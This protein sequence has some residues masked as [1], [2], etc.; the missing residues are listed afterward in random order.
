MSG[1][2]P[3]RPPSGI[4]S[5][6]G[7][8]PGSSLGSSGSAPGSAQG[9]T[10]GSSPGSSAGS[11]P[12]S[13][14]GSVPGSVPGS[15]PG[16]VPGSSLGSSSGSSQSP[17]PS[18]GS[19]PPAA[20][21]V[22]GEA[23]FATAVASVRGA[24]LRPEIALEE[25]PAPQRLAPF[26]LALS[27]DV[28]AGVGLFSAADDAD[29]ASGRLVLLHDPAGHQAWQGVFRLVTYVRA[30]LDLDMAADPLLPS[31]G[32][33]WLHEA[34]A[35]HGAEFTAIGG[36]VTLVR[37]EPFGSMADDPANAEIEIRASWTPLRAAVA[38]HVQ[39]WGDVLAQAAGLPPLPHGV[40]A[41]PVP[42]RP[43]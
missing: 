27:A 34:L 2:H 38:A 11:S 13:S 12:G 25:T 17:G 20:V 9:S 15:S 41:L 8:S 36:T 3:Q 21:P 39:A 42:R 31:V 10:Q 30:A 29:L 5:S 37:S 23:A 1:R 7:S 6:V 4:G 35:A 32:W 43:R 24:Q 16:S 26:A 28:Q 19:V 14:P 22:V 18:L 33:S 40:V